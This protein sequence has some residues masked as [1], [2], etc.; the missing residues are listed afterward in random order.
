M[1][2]KNPVLTSHDALSSCGLVLCT[3]PHSKFQI[4]PMN[5]AATPSRRQTQAVASVAAVV[6]DAVAPPLAS[7]CLN[8]MYQARVSRRCVLVDGPKPGGSWLVCPV[9]KEPVRALRA[10][11]HEPLKNRE[12]GA[13]K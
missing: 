5:V 4:D 9:A 8:G 3:A 2:C 11:P 1:P 7:M 6:V 10:E 12:A 13:R